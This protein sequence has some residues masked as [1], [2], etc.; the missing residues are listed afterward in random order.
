M[1]CLA[2]KN[3]KK[4]DKYMSSDQKL[5]DSGIMNDKKQNYFIDTIK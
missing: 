2:S 1:G 4:E 5:S 3:I